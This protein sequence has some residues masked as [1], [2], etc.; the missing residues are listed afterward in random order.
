MREQFT[1]KEI[2]MYNIHMKKFSPTVK[3]SN[4]R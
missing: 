1:E 3:K 4:L 2:M